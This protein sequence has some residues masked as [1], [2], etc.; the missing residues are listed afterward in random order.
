MS[1]VDGSSSG[2]VLNDQAI[3]VN[4]GWSSFKINEAISTDPGDGDVSGPN[5][6]V[7]NGIPRY[8]GT[9]GKIIKAG[10]AAI[11]SDAG[12]LTATTLGVTGQYTLPAANGATG[13]VITADAGGIATWTTNGAGTGDVQG[14]ISSDNNAIAT[15]SGTTGKIIQNSSVSIN[16][17]NLSAL[18]T[19]RGSLLGVN[20]VYDLPVTVGTVDQVL[21][22]NGTNAA[23]WTSDISV[24]SME[25]KG[26]YKLP[27]VKGQAGDSLT[28]ADGECVW[29]HIGETHRLLSELTYA[30]ASLADTGELALTWTPGI[31][32]AILAFRGDTPFGGGFSL[33]GYDIITAQFTNISANISLAS[34][35]SWTQCFWI[36]TP[37]PLSANA[38][39]FAVLS[40]ATNLLNAYY[41]DSSGFIKIQGSGVTTYTGTIAINQANWTHI[42]VTHNYDTQTVSLYVDGVLDGSTPWVYDR[43][44][45]P[46]D[47]I[48][49]HS[50]T[51]GEI[52]F[53]GYS[54]NVRLYDGVLS[55]NDILLDKNNTLIPVSTN[56]VTR[57][58]AGTQIASSLVSINDA[59][60]LS[61]PVLQVDGV[62]VLT[63]VPTGV[64]ALADLPFDGTIV[65]GGSASATWTASSTPVYTI[66]SKYGSNAL[67]MGTYS[68][69]TESPMLTVSSAFTISFWTK[70]P[71]NALRGI[72]QINGAP[73]GE[74]F[75]LFSDASGFLNVDGTTVTSL[76]TG[77]IAMSGTY[78]H[79][80]VTYVSGGDISVYV[81]GV[82][83]VSGTSTGDLASSA[84]L[85]LGNTDS[86]AS[87]YSGFIDNLRVYGKALDVS[88]IAND[89]DNVAVDALV[90]NAIPRLTADGLSLAG[91]GATVSKEG[92]VGSERLVVADSA[93]YPITAGNQLQ[94]QLAG[95]TTGMC[96][97][98]ALPGFPDFGNFSAWYADP[99]KAGGLPPVAVA[100][101]DD[102]GSVDEQRMFMTAQRV[103]MVAEPNDT[104]KAVF[105][106]LASGP[107]TLTT[108][109]REVGIWAVQAVGDK[110]DWGLIHSGVKCMSI[111][112][113]LDAG[114]DN[115]VIDQ[116]GT[117]LGNGGTSILT[118]D[119]TNV[120]TDAIIEKTS[121]A[122][123]RIETVLHKDGEIDLESSKKIVN[124]VTPTNAGDAVPKNYVDARVHDMQLAGVTA[125]GATETVCN[126]GSTGAGGA[127]AVPHIMM[128]PYD[129][130][131]EN[132]R[133]IADTE[134]P[135][136]TVTVR[137][138]VNGVVQHTH[139]SSTTID[140][141]SSQGPVADSGTA[142]YDALETTDVDVTAGDRVSVTVE[143]SGSGSPDLSIW[144]CHRITVGGALMAAPSKPPRRIEG[145]GSVR[146]ITPDS[147]VVV[148]DT[149]NDEDEE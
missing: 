57:Y 73:S 47:K 84:G 22:T 115:I 102:G 8:S 66:D 120:K 41:E 110:L 132:L 11:I 106:I 35:P 101:V 142:Y 130:N 116:D 63:A 105:N 88:E 104:G 30:G 113:D 127:A 28:Y 121:D 1:R 56:A 92:V 10:G 95:G 6:S 21:K 80:C 25:V 31:V 40:G 68:V 133:I 29:A 122:G 109:P 149:E 33:E 138:Y 82:L 43:V 141:W 99:T 60:T 9:S 74:Q 37:F 148:S 27:T 18:G 54:D 136:R 147:F 45:L 85:R 114:G 97:H 20:G 65:D 78:Q 51:G 128:W 16:S 103:Q 118:V 83:D 71:G 107:E 3:T 135:A 42:A 145:S 79:Y 69:S 96:F 59:G 38:G 143:L 61:A 77:T 90:A 125:S 55:A 12:A 64:T 53:D 144:L 126:W 13:Q 39:L 2:R 44:A 86:H 50:S 117:H 129:I 146:N 93:P 75:E 58:G 119:Q 48:E 140:L 5:S 123:V 36:K 131:I 111:L 134:A 70:N 76:I 91:S 72:F 124:V 32:G 34:V 89:R 87:F 67:S 7:N 112:G 137:V 26:Q 19:V 62:D 4:S 15:Y 46:V 24:A 139:T 81:D 100:S 108:A 49:Y 23:D 94:I 14:P 98:S 17:G 52:F